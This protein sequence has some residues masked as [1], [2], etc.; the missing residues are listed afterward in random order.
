MTPDRYRADIDGLRALAV[1]LVV[2]F[3]AWPAL[4]PGGFVGVDVFFV[5]SG[6]LISGIL[7]S[8]LHEQRFSF[9]DFYVR[10]VRRIF[11][12]LVVVL[13]ASYAIG[14]F[15]LFADDYQRLARHIRAGV[16]FVSN[17]ALWS[18]AGYFDGAADTKPLQHLWSLGV[19]EQFYLAWP[20]LLW[21]AWRWRIRPLW[22]TAVLLVGS[23]GLNL[24][25]IRTDLVST[26]F[27]PL[28]RF[29]QLLAG[30]MLACLP[31]E[32]AVE[33]AWRR[34]IPSDDRGRGRLA[35][36]GSAVGLTLI[37]LAVVFINQNT[38]YPGGW[39][40]LPTVGAFLIIASGPHAWLNRKWLSQPAAV[41]LGL[42]SYPLYLWH[43]PLLSFARISTGE[44][45]SL[46][47]RGGIVLLS[48][49]L[50]WLTYV[51]L[52]KP[53]RFGTLRRVAVP[54]LSTA[55]MAILGVAQYT[56]RSEG[57]IERAISRSDTAHFL[58]YYDR[59][60][61]QGISA[62][63]RQECDFMDWPTGRLRDAIDASCTE[64]GANGTWFLWG[65]S[66]AQA[67]SQGL[68]SVLPPGVRLSQ[69]TTSLC[70]PDTVDY[71]GVPDGRCRRANAFAVAQIAERRP[72][73]VILA[74]MGGHSVVDW[75]PLA[76]RIRQL[77]AGQVI[78]VGPAPQWTPS[79]PEVVVRQY[80]GQDYSRVSHGL[81]LPIL[82]TDRDLKAR[83]A[84]SSRLTYVS[85]VAALCNEQGCKA[86]VDGTTNELLTFD[87]GHLTPKGSVFVAQSILRP[88]LLPQ[89]AP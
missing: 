28:T 32:P 73:V 19:E 46:A 50:A 51:V 8:A 25:S 22:L 45:P 5:I 42:I 6:F 70:R 40:L 86:V 66:Y 59:M 11:P 71:D 44:T 24:V 2:A 67:L 55:M 29:W 10:R 79:L 77:G 80:W 54:L 78:V 52:E 4:V 65:D 33:Q 81:A 30:A 76:E 9:T 83:L 7:V 82:A 37:V 60:H 35:N 27:S 16:L 39:A 38:H 74:Q 21:L 68:R 20:L 12:A 53:V 49:G 72:Q 62:A 88:I 63:Y 36:A 47:V 64:A 43:W 75:E 84:T 61:K 87:S 15:V 17:F 56:V 3:H 26:F 23:L 58:Q 1:V 18:E 69:V 13:V 34:V 41:W 31:Y 14:W 48:V 89:A 85:L 57:L